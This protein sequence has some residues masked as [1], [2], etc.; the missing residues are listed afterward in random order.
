MRN[1]TKG[2]RKPSSSSSNRHTEAW[3]CK[4]SGYPEHRICPLGYYNTLAILH[5]H[6]TKS[7][8]FLFPCGWFH[9]HFITRVNACE[10]G[11]SKLLFSNTASMP[12]QI[13][14][15][16][17]SDQENPCTWCISLFLPGR[18]C[19]SQALPAVGDA[20]GYKEP[21]N[22]HLPMEIKGSLLNSLPLHHNYLRDNVRMDY[23]NLWLWT[24]TSI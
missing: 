11:I 16:S 21:L 5:K 23:E 18:S 22:V 9:K 6:S 17:K 12:S 20:C 8:A 3:S 15:S 19:L 10:N 14:V 1:R 13:K 7:R 4:C 24:E 2:I